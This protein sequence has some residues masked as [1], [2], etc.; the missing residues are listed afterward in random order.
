[1][2]NSFI[3]VD[4]VKKAVAFAN[5]LDINHLIKKQHIKP[6]SNYI[7]TIDVINKLQDKGWIL[8]GVSEERN[9]STFKITS[10]HIKMLHPDFSMNENGKHE[11][12]SNLLVSNS[13]TGKSPLS[14]NLGMFRK[15]CSNGL[16][17]RDSMV[18]FDIK[19]DI[20]G[21]SR[22]NTCLNNVNHTVQSNIKRFETLKLKILTKE[23]MQEL[24]KEAI[25]IRSFD[26]SIDYN[27]L[28]NINRV[29]DEGNSLWKVYNRIQENL[30]K[31]NMLVDNN[32][33]LIYGTINIQHDIRVNNNLMD[34]V[35]Q[36]I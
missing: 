20:N 27:Q 12:E 28:L 1:M 7:Q 25:K 13:C 29:E 6:V 2:K 9:K 31:D 32:G 18:E 4:S 8:N 36:F 22:L 15:V 11:A 17:R 19:H 35:E 3:P 10:H 14:I 23:E 26:S 34:L 16:F 21:I 24:A 33:K 5:S 30:T